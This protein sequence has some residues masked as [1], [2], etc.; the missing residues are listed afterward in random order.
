MLGR[1]LDWIRGR[2]QWQ[3]DDETA[4]RC[5]VIASGGEPTHSVVLRLD[6]GAMENPDLDVRW[7][8]EKTLR[9]LHPDV[10]FYDDGYG[11]ARHSDAMLLSYATNEPMRLVEA[12]VAVLNRSQ[13]SGN[14]LA[15]AAMVA[16]GPRD[17]QS[18]AGQEFANHRVVYPPQ[19]AGSLLPD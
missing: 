11:F 15:T 2:K 13:M 16:I 1:L 3:G 17:G 8:I 7:E 12:L 6:P 4:R 19:E 9:A 18:Q 14:Q 10:L 5:A